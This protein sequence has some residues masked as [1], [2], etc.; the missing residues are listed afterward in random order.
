MNENIYKDGNF[1]SELLKRGLISNSIYYY[2]KNSLATPTE[3]EILNLK[4][5]D[6]GLLSPQSILKQA[7]LDPDTVI[8]SIKEEK[9]NEKNEQNRQ[10]RQ[11]EQKDETKK[12][13]I[14]FDKMVWLYDRGLISATTLM[15]KI[16]LD[17]AYESVLREQECKSLFKDKCGNGKTTS[18]QCCNG[19][20]CCK[21]EKPDEYVGCSEYES[22]AQI[23]I[24]SVEQLSGYFTYEGKQQDLQSAIGRRTGIARVNVNGKQ[25]LVIIEDTSPQFKKECENKTIEFANEQDFKDFMEERPDLKLEES[26]QEPIATEKDHKFIWKENEMGKMELYKNGK[27]VAM[28]G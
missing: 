10:N 23:P 27:K 12:I 6:V 13:E 16:G 2:F 4:L 19:D 1:F 24:P 22:L 14:D 5:Y 11:N 7:G 17:Y 25:K 26:Y 28:Q 21:P 15:S 18:T 8:N 3:A 20:Q 9:M